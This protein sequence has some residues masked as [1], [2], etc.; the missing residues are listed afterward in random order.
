M[1]LEL[2]KKEKIKGHHCIIIIKSHQREVFLLLCLEKG[3]FF[4][5]IGKADEFKCKLS[6]L[7][8]GLE[9][10]YIIMIRIP[11]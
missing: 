1:G 3:R 4:T 2:V 9:E 10:V 7:P 8:V 5:L 11:I 6:C